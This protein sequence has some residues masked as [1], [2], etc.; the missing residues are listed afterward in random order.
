MPQR[1]VPRVR[2]SKT[3]P[4]VVGNTMYLSTPYNRLVALNSDT[5]VKLWEF[6][7]PS[8]AASRGISYWPGDGK[9]DP[10]IFRHQRRP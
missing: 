7:L 3:T 4:L 8:S 2:T 1:R 10:E 5:G 9:H 6:L